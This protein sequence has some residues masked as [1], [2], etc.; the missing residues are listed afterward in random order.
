MLKSLRVRSGQSRYRL[1]DYSGITQSYILRL[2]SGEKSNPSRKVVIKLGLSLLKGS[3]ALEIW[4][5][6][7]LLLS[8]GYA[9]LS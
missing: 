4:E 2:E 9:E 7:V 6:D 5:I 1:A 8:A 3:D